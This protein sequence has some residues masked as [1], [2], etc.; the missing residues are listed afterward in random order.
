MSGRRIDDEEV[1]FALSLLWMANNKGFR[2]ASTNIK[3]PEDSPLTDFLFDTSNQWVPPICRDRK[4]KLATKN[5]AELALSR[6][7]FE[8]QKAIETGNYLA[9]RQEVG[10]GV[11]SIFE[12]MLGSEVYSII[13]S[14]L[15]IAIKSGV[16][17]LSD[18]GTEAEALLFVSGH[19][20][21]E[22]LV[23]QRLFKGS[24]SPLY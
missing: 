11:N 16:D 17:P 23:S 14:G 1:N 5:L 9:L 4:G 2:Q 3:R 22:A 10:D 13:M 6:A 19:K 12:V 21:K 20:I 18:P 24:L 15:Q 8:S 7:K